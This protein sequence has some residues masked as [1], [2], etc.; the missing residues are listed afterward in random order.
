[1]LTV[2]END[3]S[4]SRTESVARW[5]GEG[6]AAYETEREALLFNFLFFRPV[7]GSQS[8]E[9]MLHEGTGILFF[10]SYKIGLIFIVFAVLL[11]RAVLSLSYIQQ[12]YQNKKR[13]ALPEVCKHVR[14][15]SERGGR[16]CPRREQYV[17]SELFFP[18]SWRRDS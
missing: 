7:Q 2:A 14:H 15:V 10:L 17:V 18:V 3:E 8:G 12:A 16:N 13:I 1:M 11:C 5:S 6:R 4:F 9:K